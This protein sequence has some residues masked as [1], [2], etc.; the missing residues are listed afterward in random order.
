MAGM[1]DWSISKI[2]YNGGLTC[3]ILIN[4]LR[5]VVLTVFLINMHTWGMNSVS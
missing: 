2:G 4:Y 3:N 5:V 1:L